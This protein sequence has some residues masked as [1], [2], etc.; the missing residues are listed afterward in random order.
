MTDIDP[1]IEFTDL[2]HLPFDVTMAENG[3]D[4]GGGEDRFTATEATLPIDG[5]EKTKDR[6]VKSKD[7]AVTTKD[8]ARIR[9]TKAED[10]VFRAENHSLK[11]TGNMAALRDMETEHTLKL[12]DSDSFDPKKV[13]GMFL[14]LVQV[15]TDLSTGRSTDFTGLGRPGNIEAVLIQL[16][17]EKNKPVCRSCEKDAGHFVGCISV[18]GVAN[19]TC[20]NCHWGSS[21]RRCTV[22]CMYLILQVCFLVYGCLLTV[23]T[24]D[25]NAIQNSV[26]VKNE[27]KLAK[28]AS[29]TPKR[30]PRK[31]TQIEI[32][33][34]D[35]DFGDRKKSR[36]PQTNLYD[37]RGLPGYAAPAPVRAPVPPPDSEFTDYIIYFTVLLTILQ[38]W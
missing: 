17:G 1:R 24:A 6:A 7:K 28:S 25:Y 2:D 16:K 35:D 14:Q 18:D 34:D 37:F 33:D 10:T 31:G 23:F 12:R 5:A 26:K 29:V 20:G 21:G 30:R 36:Y 9:R 4:A 19:G 8:P 13:D 32:S 27:V 15:K 11:V 38:L 22:R 3:A